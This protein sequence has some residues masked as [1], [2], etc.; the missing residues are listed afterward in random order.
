ML[1][2]PSPAQAAERTSLVGMSLTFAFAGQPDREESAGLRL[3]R[4]VLANL[5]IFGQDGHHFIFIEVGHVEPIVRDAD[6][7]RVIE[8][9]GKFFEQ[10]VVVAVGRGS[11]TF[12]DEYI[13]IIFSNCR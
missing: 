7:V 9:L 4:E 3:V 10:V 8:V 2:W 11:I 6:S 5:A 1:T 12:A 13:T